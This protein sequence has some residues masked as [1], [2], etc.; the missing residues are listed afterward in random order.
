MFSFSSFDA[1]WV[2]GLLMAAWYCKT[3]FC[4]CTN[5]CAM[6]CLLSCR[7]ALIVMVAAA[8]IF[9]CSRTCSNLLLALLP[10]ADDF[11]LLV[12]YLCGLVYS[13]FALLIVF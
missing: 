12:I 13:A 10:Q 7:G 4:A 9:W 1:F 2:I 6:L 5:V 11:K 8:V 3:G